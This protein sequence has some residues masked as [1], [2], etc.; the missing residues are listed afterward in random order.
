MP[1]EFQLQTLDATA[2]IPCSVSGDAYFSSNKMP[3][4]F[5]HPSCRWGV[6]LQSSSHDAD[7]GGLHTLFCRICS[8]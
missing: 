2:Y 7:L 1:A 5:T 8:I 3:V 6:V 4:D